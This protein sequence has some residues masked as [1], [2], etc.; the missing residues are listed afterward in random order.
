MPQNP[1]FDMTVSSEFM[2]KLDRLIQHL[3]QDGVDLRYHST[4]PS[5]KRAIVYAVDMLLAKYEENPESVKS[6]E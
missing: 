6:S 3:E 5:R 4:H 1:R 2:E